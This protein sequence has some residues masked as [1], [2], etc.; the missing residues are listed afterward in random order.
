MI[1]WKRLLEIDLRSTK[2]KKQLIIK[3]KEQGNSLDITVVGTKYL[4]VLK[5][6]FKIIIKNLTYKEVLEIIDGEYFEVEIKA[7]YESTGAKSIFKGSVMYVSNNLEDR[8]TNEVIILCASKLIAAY[9][10]SRMNLSLNS[11]INMYS[12]LN[13]ILKR[14]GIQNSYID[15]DFKDR[16]IKETLNISSSTASWLDAFTKSNNFVSNVDATL[17]NGVSIWSPYRKDSRIVKVTNKTIL[18]TGGY[19]TVSSEGVLLS[20]LPT[21]NFVPGDTI[22]IDNSIIDVS[23]QSQTE[24]TEN[25]AL[26]ISTNGRY[27]IYQLEYN[28]TNRNDEFSINILAK[29]KDVIQKIIGGK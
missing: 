16:I 13:Y 12:A 21:F 19:P 11:G 15:E 29:S 10:Q 2:R 14:A 28:L 27:L 26:Y 3:Q 18:L 5:D 17:G 1:A 22:Q 9:G 8:K 25:Q 24:I 6:N 20:V 23:I 4:S 7:G